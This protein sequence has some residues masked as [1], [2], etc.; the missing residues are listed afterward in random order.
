MKGAKGGQESDPKPENLSFLRFGPQSDLLFLQ[1]KVE[2]GRYNAVP[3]L[4]IHLASAHLA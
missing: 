3:L 2:V 1:S 4:S